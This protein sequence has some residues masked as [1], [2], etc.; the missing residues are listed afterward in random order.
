MPEHVLTAEAPGGGRHPALLPGEGA[1]VA[2]AVERRRREFAEGRDCAHRVLAALGWAGFPVLSGANRE[3]LWPPGVL[4]SI[5]HCEGYV[6]AAAARVSDL[7]SIRSLGIDA[8]VRAPLGPEVARLVLTPEEQRRTSSSGD[9]TLVTAHFSAK[10]AV[11]KSWFPLTGRWLDYQ[12][13]ELDLDP[14]SGRFEVRLLPSVSEPPEALRFSGRV[15][16]GAKH[17]FAVAT[18]TVIS[19]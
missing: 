1:L 18:A 5:T 2:N 6:A 11:Y 8:E 13:A 7:G 10:E 3:P 19:S 9:A 17:V 4:G 12:D 15:A 16:A 14:A